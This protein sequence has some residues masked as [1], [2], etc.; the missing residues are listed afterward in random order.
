M[1]VYKC[2]CCHIM[3]AHVHAFTAACKDPALHRLRGIVMALHSYG[4][5]S[6]GLHSDDIYGYGMYGYGLQALHA[7]TQPFIDGGE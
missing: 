1:R 7:R 2:A 3:Q 4:P 6:H 5:Y